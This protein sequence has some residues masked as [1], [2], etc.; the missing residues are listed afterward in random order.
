MCTTKH[1]NMNLVSTLVKFLFID[2]IVTVAIDDLLLLSIGVYTY[3]VLYNRLLQIQN[4][5]LYYYLF[6]F[7]KNVLCNIND[8][9]SLKVYIYIHLTI[10]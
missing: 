3:S 2:L 8:W 4:N 1:N 7:K 6:L 9:N 10:Q 5:V